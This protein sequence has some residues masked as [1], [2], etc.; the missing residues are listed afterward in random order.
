MFKKKKRR[1]KAFKSNSR[2]ID[3]DDARIQRKK[4]RE[5]A[6]KK[7]AGAQKTKPVITERKAGKLAR[8]RIVYF[9]I[10][11]AI[12]CLIGASAI[13]IVSVKLSE[14]KTIEEQQ[15][16]LKQKEKLESEL[17]QVNDPKY[18]EQQARQQLGMIKP[19]EILYVLPEQ[20]KNATK[21]GII[22]E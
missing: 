1:S 18:I 3:I 12:V 19:G 13:N 22:P 17:S 4:K 11:I 15:A 20:E 9:F 16:L 6:V 8:R 21:A 5:E 7:K 14:A 10:F 2:I